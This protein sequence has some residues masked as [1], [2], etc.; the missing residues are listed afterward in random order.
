VVLLSLALVG[1][2]SSSKKASSP[3]TTAGASPS[4]ASA[5][6]IKDFTFSP[7]TLQVKVGAT[8]KVTNDDSPTHTWTGDD[9]SWDE[10]LSP[11]SSA[12][13]TFDKAGTFSYHCSIHSSMKGTV[14]VS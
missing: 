5:I 14:V 2:G 6:S 10:R 7:S 11:G 9:G 3:G 1:C 12:T 8:V 4:S 13:H